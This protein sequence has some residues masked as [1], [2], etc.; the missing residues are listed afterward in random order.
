MFCFLLIVNTVFC[1]NKY[2]FNCLLIRYFRCW[3]FLSFRLEQGLFH[4]FRI[5]YIILSFWQ[6][7]FFCH[8]CQVY[9]IHFSIILWLNRDFSLMVFG[10]IPYF[11]LLKLFIFSAD[12]LVIVTAGILAFC[13]SDMALSFN[14]LL[15]SSLIFCSAANAYPLWLVVDIVTLNVS[16][17]SFILTCWNSLS[18]CSLGCLFFL[19]FWTSI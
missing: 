1:W 5:Y 12:C 19:L 9:L 8:I 17:R 6:H 14:I 2:V 18:T 13:L 10:L 15:F 11:S 16:L 3:F 7:I 4:W